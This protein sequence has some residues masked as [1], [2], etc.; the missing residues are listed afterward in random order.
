M[1][2]RGGT[3]ESFGAE[4]EAVETLKLLQYARRER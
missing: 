1:P 4:V 3:V 2:W